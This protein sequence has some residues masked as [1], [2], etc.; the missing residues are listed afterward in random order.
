LRWPNLDLDGAVMDVSEQII[1]VGWQTEVTTPKS[2]SDGLV[3]LD[4][5]TV[6][7]LRAHRRQQ[8]AERLAWGTAWTNTGYVFTIE[9]GQPVLPDYVSR[10]FVRLVR[11]A[12][13]LKIGSRG[14]AVEDVQRALGVESSG[15][16]GQDA[17][18]GRLYVST[19]PR[20]FESQ[21]HR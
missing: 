8:L 17:R 12:N 20:R 21:R 14:Q 6:A 5:A 4:A 2:D 18:A 11:H 1:Q 19:R 7:V 10:H 9:T 3:V 15:V 16:Y 13:E